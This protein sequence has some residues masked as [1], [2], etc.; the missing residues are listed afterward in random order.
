M[1]YSC[2][3]KRRHN[4]RLTRKARFR[5][6]S[7]PFTWVLGRPGISCTSWITEPEFHTLGIRAAISVGFAFHSQ[8]TA[9]QN[10]IH[11]PMLWLTT[12][13]RR[14]LGLKCPLYDL[15]L[16]AR[17]NRVCSYNSSRFM[18]VLQT[19]SHTIDY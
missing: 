11:C 10:R 6:E 15:D 7:W 4:R 19:P 12:A 5:V 1:D 17:I 16:A 9:V 3:G 18:P 8:H 14:T 13:S 2:R